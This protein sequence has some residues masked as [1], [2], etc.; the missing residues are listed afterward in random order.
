MHTRRITTLPPYDA[1]AAQTVAVEPLAYTNDPYPCLN[2]GTARP[3]GR[4]TRFR[5]NKKVVDGSSVAVL[6]EVDVF[7]PADGGDPIIIP[8]QNPNQPDDRLLCVLNISGGSNN[9]TP[10]TGDG[11]AIYTAATF[12]LVNCP[13][14]GKTFPR[15]AQDVRCVRCNTVLTQG[16]S[17]ISHPKTGAIREWGTFPPPGVTILA[18]GFACPAR[19]PQDGYRVIAALLSKN[20]RVRVFRAGHVPKGEPS[21]VVICWNGKEVIIGTDEL[22]FNPAPLD[23]DLSQGTVL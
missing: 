3:G 11:A 7:K 13:Q 15:N 14:Q 4:L 2:L 19:G 17:E 10:A 8:R 18:E 1:D 12:S 6:G 9:P 21:V 16:P 20:A 22:S 23:I 5:I